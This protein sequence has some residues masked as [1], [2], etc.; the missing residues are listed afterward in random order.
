MRDDCARMSPPSATDGPRRQRRAGGQP[1]SHDP[2]VGDPGVLG[3]LPN[4]RPQRPSARRA[5]ARRTAARRA[6]R[7]AEAE[8]ARP[9]APTP[10]AGAPKKSRAGSRAKPAA[11]A[12]RA[13]SRAKPA[14]KAARA[15]SRAKPAAKAAPT[16][17]EPPVP[18]QGFESE[19]P[20]EPG[21]PVQP[22]SGPELAASAAELV[23]ELAQAG[24]ATGGR[25]LGDAL[26]RLS[27]G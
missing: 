23:V 6:E 4:S 12:A 11:K 14:A 16:I 24:L 1:R 9:Q 17:A 8:P 21:R 27:G 20:I 19:E 10:P 18:P 15:G 3:S 7:A 2:E 22:P 5:A 26:K 25:L 13:G